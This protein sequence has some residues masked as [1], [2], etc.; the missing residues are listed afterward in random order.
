MDGSNS[1]WWT[2]ELEVFLSLE[3]EIAFPVNP[4]VPARSFTPE[5]TLELQSRSQTPV[6][7]SWHGLNPSS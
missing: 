1:W 6:L 2:W 3:H 7:W 5:L 4:A